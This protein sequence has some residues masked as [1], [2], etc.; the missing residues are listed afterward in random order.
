MIKKIIKRI[1]L[2]RKGLILSEKS[3]INYDVV[4]A[5]GFD[6][7]NIVDSFA[8]IKKIGNKCYI[9]HAKIYG[10][11]YIGNYVSISGPGT[12]IHSGNSAIKIGNFVSIAEN[13]SIQGFNHKSKRPTTC[14]I[15][16]KVF[17]EDF[18]EDI[19]S[20]GDIIIQD[21]VWV[22]SNAVILS[23]VKIG[24]GSIIAAG[25]V[26]TKDVSPYTIV[27]GIPA[28][29]IKMRFP[30]DVIEK[31]EK[32]KWWEWSDSEIKKNRDFFEKDASIF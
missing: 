3:E 16:F 7:S 30:E 13:V 28:K 29:F 15:L 23:G 9:E 25:A 27:G 20:K 11:V 4:L 2:K 19:D 18:S 31:L 14:P 6:R 1:L 22:G 32:M 10:N 12:I 17:E 24:R 21:D 26:V 8:Q 5:E